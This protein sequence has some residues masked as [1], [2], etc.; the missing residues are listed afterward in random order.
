MSPF[1]REVRKVDGQLA[2]LFADGTDHQFTLDVL[3]GLRNTIHHT[4]LPEIRV[5]QGGGNERTW[6]AIREDERDPVLKA[7]DAL[8]GR[9]A[10]GV[11]ETSP[12]ELQLDPG[13]L[14]DQLAIH[15]AKLVVA[16][17]K[18]TPVTRLT[19][20]DPDQTFELTNPLDD[21]QVDAYTRVRLQLGLG[22]DA[23]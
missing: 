9:R 17:Q 1:L 23:D 10:W 21:L 5:S 11:N 6:V 15:V 12:D 3:A 16:V 7:A 8:G 14:A 20:V 22:T 4:A 18:A 13:R 2:G 19:K